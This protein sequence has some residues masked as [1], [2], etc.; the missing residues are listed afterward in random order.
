[1]KRIY[2]N[3]KMM[4]PVLLMVLFTSC[5]K[6]F[7]DL[8][9]DP[10][11]VGVAL[12]S[13]FLSNALYEAAT[14]L[15]TTGHT[16]NDQLMQVN[17]LRQ[18]DNEIHRYRITPGNF[19]G[20][21][22]ALYKPMADIREMTKLA[23]ET[24]SPNYQAIGLTLQAWI[25]SNITDI[26]G[27]VPFTEALRGVEGNTTPK[28][29]PQE[30]IYD[31]IFAYLE[32]ANSLYVLNQKLA[33]EDL[34]YN[35]NNVAANM[36]KWKKFTNSLRLRLLMRVE[37]KGTS[38][39]DQ[40]RMMLANSAQ[41]PLMTSVQDGAALYYSGVTP[42]LN[43]FFSYRDF[44]FN[45]KLNYSQYF[46]DYLKNVGDPR[47]PVYAT[48]VAGGI[49]RGVPTGYPVADQS[50]ITG[51][52]WS[53]YQIALKT[54]DKMGSILQY[55]ELEFLLA[56]AALKGFSTDDPQLHYDKGIKASMD[57]WGITSIPGSFLT[58]P[59]IAWDGTLEQII[60]QKYFSQLGN[61]FEQW[62]EYRRTGF[63]VLLP[64]AE[65]DNNGVMPVRIP[66]P[67]TESLYNGENYEEAVT[68]MGG[69][70]INVKVWWQQ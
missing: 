16:I 13:S 4:A 2:S 36:L 35:S 18:N 40:I 10:E 11:A 27:D 68:R 44:D 41:Y 19:N 5:L 42:F 60:T 9:K 43:P 38:Y 59:D 46:I 53:T 33:G 24:N 8:R 6:K 15:V 29:D 20:M 58:H 32:R 49:Y 51:T 70:D 62:Y 25:I 54:N 34:L 57:Y 23:V 28:F 7:D 65:M 12:P 69:D 1:M 50:V 21:W 47:L 30:Q 17:V 67:L 3:R 61:G 31:S 55:A 39:Q 45:E 22:N 66:Y 56:E 64:G 37:K 52:A 63:P 48:S 14:T 26:Y